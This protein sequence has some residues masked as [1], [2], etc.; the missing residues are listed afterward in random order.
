MKRTVKRIGWL[1]LIAVMMVLAG[2]KKFTIKNRCCNNEYKIVNT[3][4]VLPDSFRLYIPQAFTPNY[5]G[6][7]DIFV[8]FGTNFKIE[9]FIIKRANKIVFESR[10]HVE[11]FWNGID[12]RDAS[13]SPDGRYTYTMQLRLSNNELLN[14]K[15]D[16]CLM[17]FGVA[18]DNLYEAERDEICNC[19][20][21][22]M[23][24]PKKG[25]VSETP[26]CP[27]NGYTD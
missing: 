20:M 2:C 3:R 13:E 4:Y 10:V 16:V 17:R 27:A 22:D 12:S 15:G 21:G 9:E 6:L 24:D 5:D 23:I 26:E 8:P 18:G 1:G 7:N 11:A 25:I 14:I 19:L